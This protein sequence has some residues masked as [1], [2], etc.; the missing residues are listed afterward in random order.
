MLNRRTLRV[1][2][3]Q[4]LFAFHQSREANYE[5]AL[6]Y[7]ADTFSPDLNSME[8]QDK[9]QLKIDKKAAIVLFK[10]EFKNAAFKASY[11]IRIEEIVSEAIRECL[12]KNSK[13][14][15]HYAKSMVMEAE[16]IV[17]RYILLLLLLVELAELAEKDSKIDHSKFVK[18]L[19]ITSIRE[20]KAIET[21]KLRRNLNWTNESDT[22]R[23][24]FK[25]LLKSDE[26]YLEYLKST[27]SS[28]EKDQALILYLVKNILF[29]SEV[30]N[31]YMEEKDLSWDE[32]RAIVKSLLTKT[33][34]S[35]P[36]DEEGFELQELSYNWDDDKTFFQKLFEETI[37]V[38]TQYEPLIAEK[39]KNW[40]I[41]RIAV[42]DKIII[43]MAIAEMIH[44]PSIPVKVT[45]N[46]YI[47]VAKRY[48]TPK[49]KTF[50]NGIL[51][52]IANELENS[53]V[54][55]KSGRGLIDNK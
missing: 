21:I 40:D 42:T 1:K 44:F 8:V 30:I 24:W 31:A 33:L 19:L 2:A 3:M 4:T 10:K 39:A 53:G 47:E 15:R 35:I 46:E 17:D 16:K 13:D 32:D 37:K 6:E 38:E 55:R 52:A 12:Q 28:F 18:N 43:E 34:K 49:S 23:S 26:S 9:E 14:H 48:S 51:D 25:E 27:D 20:N 45:I 50:I 36:E 22:L 7:I 29:K 11:E 54:I 5:L 41:D